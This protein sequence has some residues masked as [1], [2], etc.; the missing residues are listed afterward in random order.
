MTKLFKRITAA[1]M[2][3]VMAASATVVASA[4]GDE[5]QTTKYV[6]KNAS[7]FDDGSFIV[8]ANGKDIKA[9]KSKSEQDEYFKTDVENVVE[10]YSGGKWTVMV[11]PYKD[12]ST[13]TAYDVENFL[14]LFT[15]STTGEG[16]NKVTVYSSKLTSEGKA[17]QKAGKQLATAKIKEGKI[18]VTAGKTAGK[19]QVWIYEVKAKQIVYSNV[20]DGQVDPFCIGGET[21]MAATAIALTTTNPVADGVAKK[22]TKSKLADIKV[23]EERT[24]YIADTK[25][26]TVTDLVYNVTVD[27]KEVKLGADNS[28]TVKPTATGKLKI[29]VTCEE[30]GKKASFSAK[31]VAAAKTDTT[32]TDTAKKYTV[33]ATDDTTLYYYNES[34][35]AYEEVTTSVEFDTDSPEI[36]LDVKGKSK[37]T[38]GDDYTVTEK[39]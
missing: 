19:F 13:N 36:F 8:W 14:K 6:Y 32:N 31:V 27:G 21:K 37:A 16:E 28:F 2:A 1:A 30:S 25:N 33:A 11:T 4:D 3:V 34:T 10:N 22:I 29:T 7:N 12:E 18:T 17:V 24:Y 15:S 9:K 35:S 23:G 39:K 5:V 26:D 38:K 20:S